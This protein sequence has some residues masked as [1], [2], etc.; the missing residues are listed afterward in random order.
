MTL[1]RRSFVAGVATAL[2]LPAL[3][4]EHIDEV[5]VVIVGAGPAGIAAGKA[6]QQARRSFVILEA[7][8]R[9]GGRVFTDETL[10]VPFEAGAFYIHWAER[11]PWAA[12]ASQLDVKT[13][14]DRTLQ[15]GFAVFDDGQP[16]SEA[17]R[18]SRRGAYR[19]ISDVL[20][21]YDHERDD[22][23]ADLVRHQ[24][25]EIV[26]AAA[27]M[28]LMSLGEDPERVSAADYD[29]LDSGTDLAVPSGY[30]KL[31]A[32]YGD[33]LPVRLS[34]PV[35]AID[36]SGEGVSVAT[37]TAGTVKA[38]AVIVTVPLG[39]LAHEDIF[40]APALPDDTLAAIAG[41]RMGAM[42]KLALRVEGDRL[43]LSPFT[44][45]FDQ[46]A[47]HELINFE[48]W[49]FD[50]NVILATF[51]G[52][53]AR[54]VAGMGEAGAVDH[55]TE[56]LL[57]LTGSALRDKIK[58][59]RLA[60][61]SEDPFAHGS[62]SLALPGHAKARDALFRPV[63]DRIWFAGEAT[64]GPAAMTAGGAAI[65]GMAAAQTIAGKLA[66]GNVSRE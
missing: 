14:D 11:N 44:Q 54:G 45:Y 36:W 7:R 62:Y 66:A 46:S 2:A 58:A 19:R 6:L 26:M 50:Q 16:V 17:E 48:F 59:G 34:N 28:A 64:A 30:G 20:S 5:D 63:G 9:I 8:E 55:V 57:K 51:G 15:G 32:R 53:Y 39:V 35:T 41:L 49:T 52:D 31:V 23:F 1:S 43:G 25:P 42:T 40:F 29:Q 18:S 65:T 22:S 10:G 21:A 56:R 37:A 27:G 33:G 4:Q 47:G 13:V 12:I 3:A 38:R 61:W 60:G 24:P